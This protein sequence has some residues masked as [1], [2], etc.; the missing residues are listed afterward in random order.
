LPIE[1][2]MWVEKYRPTSLGELV[3]QEVV[4][5]RLEALL[6]KKQQLPHLLFAG[7]PGS[8]K[9]TTA[10]I[11]ARQIL[12]DHWRDYT[13]E[14]NASDERGIETVRQR[15]KIFARYTDRPEGVPFRLVLLDEAD[16][17]TND[18]QTA[19]RR[20]MEENSEHTR[21]IL[22]C[23]SP[24]T[25]VL[26][27]DEILAK[28]TEL[29]QPTSIALSSFG[30]SDMRIRTDA[31]IG[32]IEL[33]PEALGK[34]CLRIVTDTS[35]TIQLTEDHP[36]W[37]SHGW[38]P[39]GELRPGDRVAVF[40]NLEGTRLD[41]RAEVILNEASYA[42]RID[43]YEKRI[44]GRVDLA[45]G[46][47]FM[48][49]TSKGK[50]TVRSEVTRLYQA[51]GSAFSSTT[52]NKAE[53]MRIIE[54]RQGIKISYGAIQDIIRGVR[55]RGTLSYGIAQLRRRGLLPL[56]YDNKKIGAIVR[57][58]AF[59]FGDGCLTMNGRRMIFTG[60]EDVLIE[61]KKDITSLEFGSGP[62]ESKTIKT[63]ID[64]RDVIGRT[65]SFYVDSV[66]LWT[67]LWCLGAPVG[68]KC[69]QSYAV[70]EWVLGGTRLVQR[71]FIRVFFD[72]EAT[73]P[74]I[75]KCNFD[76]ISL[77]QHKTEQHVGGGRHFLD[78]LADL[79]TKFNCKSAVRI[80]GPAGLRKDGKLTF[81]IKL[82]L[83]SSGENLLSYFSQV[84]FRYDVRKRLMARL[85]QEYLRY[86][87][88]RLRAQENI[89]SQVSVA[90]TE[91]RMTAKQI[92]IEFGCST[93]FVRTVSNSRATK[94]PR[95]GLLSFSEW[96]EGHW[97]EDSELVWETVEESTL[98]TLPKV[99]D[100]TTARDHS[101]IAG[102]FI[103]HNCNYSSGIIEPLQSRCAIFR[104]Q[105][106]G[107]EAVI[108]HLKS[109]A[110]KEKLKHSGETVFGE[111][112]EATQGDLRQAINLMQAAAA[113]GDLTTDS[114]KSVSGASV[115]AR[116]AEIIGAAVAGD[117]EGARTKMVELTRVYGIP[118]RDFLRFA[119]E[120]LGSMKVPDMAKAISILA[121]Y[122]FRLVQ[123]SQPELQLTA[124]LAQLSSLKK[125]AD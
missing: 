5:Q 65:T 79:L 124:M 102:G 20:I 6:Q 19:L 47:M 88:A 91:G 34:K 15:I 61:V 85:G 62:I 96:R 53:V 86:K 58:L 90:L 2:L 48:E 39:A 13:L 109:I 51:V 104:F 26:L 8:G 93:D 67:L 59:V 114:V 123:G 72:C 106:Y 12:G 95:K 38:I 30:E 46:S 77:V 74:T 66:P 73:T 97:I 71:E 31:S 17:T 92:A 27:P 60:R 44:Q 101:F 113:S 118:E 111:I 82:D 25:D 89:A 11:I 117:F 64:G 107:E 3:D 4:K 81:K 112:Y 18:A 105:R 115:K 80:I 100:I 56:S 9:T 70:P 87:N 69:D 16:E 54:G 29:Q 119:N 108:G 103:S 10:L 121:E 45:P 75:D 43:E 94:M 14:L 116:V 78:Q 84:G 41:R 21:F 122:D 22:I 28:I 125:K 37:T 33:Q 98:I 52:K 32:Y 42:N 36:L 83:A 40:P 57:I 110:K 23:V 35:R 99:V 50:E 24:D 120:A 63:K 49:L 76:A 55:S 1:D 68:D 7:P